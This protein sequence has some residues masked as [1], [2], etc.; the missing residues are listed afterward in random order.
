MTASSTPSLQAAGSFRKRTAPSTGWNGCRGFWSGNW[1]HASIST[2]II[3]ISINIHKYPSISINVDTT[4]ILIPIIIYWKP[5][6]VR[7]Q[8]KYPDY[9]Y[10]WPKETGKQPQSITIPQLPSEVSW[11]SSHHG[12]NPWRQGQVEPP[13]PETCVAHVWLSCF[14]GACNNQCR[15]HQDSQSLKN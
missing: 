15:K 5:R 6:D 13:K 14:T 7:S 4:N 12:P 10:W 11:V 1:Q 2:N 9:G 3:S 8:N